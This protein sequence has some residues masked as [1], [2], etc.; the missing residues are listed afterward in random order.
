[1]PVVRCPRCG[2]LLHYEA[3]LSWLW[4]VKLWWLPRRSFFLPLPDLVV[5]FLMGLPRPLRPDF[6]LVG[7][8]RRR[9][10]RCVHVPGS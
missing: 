9:W 10:N 4:L 5:R 6:I 1:V 2:A 8:A 3:D 7:V